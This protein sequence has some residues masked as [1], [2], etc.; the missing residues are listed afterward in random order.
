MTPGVGYMT[1]HDLSQRVNAAKARNRTQVYP[2]CTGPFYPHIA[3]VVLY[4]KLADLVVPIHCAGPFVM[5]CHYNVAVMVVAFGAVVTEGSSETVAIR[6]V[7][8]ARGG[9]QHHVY[10][11]VCRALGEE[12]LR[13][14]V[15]N[16]PTVKNQFPANETTI[17]K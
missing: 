15:G 13:L 10:R 16:R 1:V 12:S 9:G 3:R 6:H 2:T 14:S 5:Y 8:S 4:F 7:T 17:A 11:V